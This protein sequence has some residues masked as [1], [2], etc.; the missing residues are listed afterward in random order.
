VD[1]YIDLPT[2]NFDL[3]NVDPLDEIVEVGYRFTRDLLS[4]T[5]FPETFPVRERAVPAPGSP[6]GPPEPAPPGRTSSGR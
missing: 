6:A 3:F 1:L 4:R 5:P 2:E